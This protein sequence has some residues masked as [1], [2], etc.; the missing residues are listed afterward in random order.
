VS[1][2][3]ARLWLKAATL[4]AWFRR[5]VGKR[6]RCARRG[7]PVRRGTDAERA[8]A[9][10][11]IEYV[12]PFLSAEELWRC[13]PTISRREARRIL[14][15]YRLGY[16]RAHARIEHRLIWRR[17]GVVWSVDF[18]Q[19]PC[20]V[21]GVGHSIM[22]VRDVAG[23][24]ALAVCVVSGERADEALRVLAVLFA[25]HGAPL[26]LKM[27]NGSAFIAEALQAF[28]RHHGVVPLY[29]PPYTPEYN[30]TCEAGNTWVKIDA[31]W[32]A[33][34]HD[35]AGAWAEA[36]L[37]HALQRSLARAALRERSS[38]L[39]RRPLPPEARVVFQRELAGQ[40]A[41][42]QARLGMPDHETLRRLD[43]AKLDRKAVPAALEK[44]QYL[45]VTRRRVTPPI[46]R[47]ITR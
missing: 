36:D 8:G 32:S 20:E 34:R 17:P 39:D 24:E 16:R 9:W 18:T 5:W 38:P 42:W 46:R 29:S 40:R 21:A 13:C 19:A 44:L 10:Q 27:D 35:R 4:Q 22:V 47:K 30:G 14:T 23:K 25:R 37:Q 41:A 28:L 43:K 31:Q 45:T 1:A 7:R 2:A 12:G 6:W 26:V 11:R 15:D 33:I 3:A